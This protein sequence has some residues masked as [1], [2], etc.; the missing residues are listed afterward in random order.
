MKNSINFFVSIFLVGTFLING[1]PAANACGPSA[2]SPTFEYSYAPENPYENFAAGKIGIV[3]PGYHRSV[4]FAAYRYLNGGGFSQN[5]QKNL[6]EVWN[7]DFNNQDYQTD[8]VAGAVKSWIERRKEVADK[9]DKLPEIYTEREYGGYDF[10]PNCTSSAF[11]TA[12]KTLAD[13][14]AS[15]GSDNKDVKDWTRAQDAVFTNC[16]SGKQMP[17]DANSAMTEWLQKDRAY[18]LAAAEFYS[19]NYSEAKRLFSE[20]AQDS[21][22]PW[23][24]TA[25]YLVARTLIRQASLAKSDEKSNSF[26][27]EA[28]EQLQNLVSKGNKFSASAEKLQGLIKYRLHPQERTRELAQRLAFQSGDEN[29]RQ[30]LIDYSWL[31]DKFEKEALEAEDKR[32]EEEKQKNENANSSDANSMSNTMSNGSMSNSNSNISTGSPMNDDRENLLIVTFYN[33]DYSKSWTIYVEPGATDD[34]AI[35]EAEKVSEKLTDKMKEQVRA[36]R[37]AAYSGRFSQDYK[38]G[39]Q[40]GYYGSSEKSLSVLPEFLRQDDLTDWLFAFQFQNAE[41]YL[42]SLSKFKQ[43]NSDL[44]LMTALSKADKNSTELKSLLDAAGRMSRNSTAFPTAA[45]HQ[46]R[47][48]IEQG[49][50]AEARRLLDE[51]LNAPD[52]L[53]VSSRNQFLE[54]RTNLSETLDEFLK[55][56]QRKPFAFDY[57]GQGGTIEDFIR[58]EKSY[59][60]P[61]YSDGKTREENDAEVEEQFKDEKV[62]QDRVMFDYKTVDTMN[63]HFPVS[64]LLEAEKSPALPDYLRERFALAVWT[65]SI[66]LDDFATANKIAPE[67]LKFKPEWKDSFE[68]ISNA[69]TPQ[70]KQDAALFF[71]L[72]NPMLTP[73]IEAGLGRTDNEFG[74]FDSD[75]WWCAPYETDSET[76]GDEAARPSTKPRFLT[77]TQTRMAQTERKTLIKT[78]DAPHFLGGKVLDWA[79]RAPADKRVPESLLVVYRANGWTKFGCGNNEELREQIGGVMKKR[80]PDSEWTQKMDA[81]ENQ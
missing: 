3:K 60:N 81:D 72:K 19:L 70:A 2:L 49:K 73:F 46:T 71:I 31:L 80:Y 27:A 43:T 65:R 57:D 44:W 39:Y 17:D 59:Y 22:S 51:I 79:K 63:T 45:F 26:Y 10:F 4:L 66:V 74:S 30:N 52:E 21:D 50:N 61:E 28:E 6:V 64:V 24:E 53:P 42:Y 25:D 18:Q 33:D 77:E 5:E 78:G 32:R 34:E 56:A 15:Y 8:D 58:I 37:Q 47:I 40:G 67:V 36:A 48:L 68:K 11:E 14:I 7:A 55:Y 76:E 1:L 38:N 69:K 12:A 41:S 16:S 9:E 62:W 54:L 35:A 13:R 29:F 23:R 75:D 20:I